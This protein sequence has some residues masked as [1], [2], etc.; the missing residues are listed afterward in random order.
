MSRLFII[1]AGFSKAIANAPLAKE[2]IH[3]IYEYSLDKD[4]LYSYRHDTWDKDRE[5]FHKLLEH[6]HKTIKPSMKYLGKKFDI[7]NKDFKGFLKSTNIEFICSLLDLYLKHPFKPEAKNV[8]LGFP[9]PLLEF[10]NVSELKSALS[11][12]KH[13]LIELLMEENLRIKKEVFAEMANFFQ[14]GD[15]IISFNY[16][17]LVEQMLWQRELW[18]PFDGY[19]VSKFPRNGN[20]DVPESKVQ[21]IKI[22][23]SINW[24]SDRLFDPDLKIINDHPFKDK[25]LFKGLN[26]PESLHDKV[27][28]RTYPLYS[29]VITPTFMKAPEYKWE[30]ELINTAMEFCRKADEVLILGYSFPDADY[31]T[32]LLFSQINKDIDLKIILWHAHPTDAN[33][34]YKG[35]SQKFDFN[36]DKTIYERTK[37]EDW[38][39]NNFEY[40]YYEQQQKVIKE[41]GL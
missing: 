12:I 27:K 36:E 3:S 16:D 39:R 9:I 7:L 13:T 38:I 8:D 40:V 14:E 15:C 37:I 30:I 4:E 28:Y 41:L 31:I 2:L 23:G 33:N 21:V 25:P 34:F 1:G 19:A 6:L 26:I 5:S 24:R 17:L 29:H 32:N 22:H 35:I 11:F 18:N 20:E 10:F